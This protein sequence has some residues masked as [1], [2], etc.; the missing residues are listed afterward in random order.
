MCP[1]ASPRRRNAFRL[2][3]VAVASGDMNSLCARKKSRPRSNSPNLQV[4]SRVQNALVRQRDHTTSAPDHLAAHSDTPL[5]FSPSVRARAT[6]NDVETGVKINP[7]FGN[8]DHAWRR[9]RAERQPELCSSACRPNHA[10]TENEGDES[11]RSAAPQPRGF[12]AAAQRSR[13]P[14]LE[15]LGNSTDQDRILRRETNQHNEPTW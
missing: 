1:P 4:R 2:T 7:N 8:P 10:D 5:W 13:P 11:S 9:P 3:S 12:H 14:V 6:A 15:L